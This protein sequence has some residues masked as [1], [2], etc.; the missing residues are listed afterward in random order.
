MDDVEAYV[1]ARGG[2]RRNISVGMKAV[3]L[4]MLYPDPDKSGV[5]SVYTL[6][7]MSKMS[8]SQARKVLR[9]LPDLTPRVQDGS[10]TPGITAMNTHPAAKQLFPNEFKLFPKMP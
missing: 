10:R 7:G 2:Q 3:A 4:S 1:W 9:V 6:D 8:L 5:N